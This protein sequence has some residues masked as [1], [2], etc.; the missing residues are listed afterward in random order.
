[1][2]RILDHQQHWMR[3]DKTLWKIFTQDINMQDMVNSIQEALDC[4]PWSGSIK[5]FSGKCDMIHLH[6]YTTAE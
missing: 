4:M 5:G 2:N 1:M 3:A 6:K